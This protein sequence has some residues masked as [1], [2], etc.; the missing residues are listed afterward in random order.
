MTPHRSPLAEALRALPL[1]ALLAPSAA[2]GMK[3]DAYQEIRGRYEG[4]TLRLRVDL[5]QMT[6]ARPPNVVSLDGIGH[7]RE[8]ARVLFGRL[9]MVYIERV[10][11]EGGARLGLTIYRTQQEADRFRASN[12]PQ[13]SF[14]NPNYGR[15]LAAFAQLGSTSVD[16]EL[17][18]PK[19]ESEAQVREIETLLNRVFYLDS[20]PTREEAEDF[21]RQHAGLPVD[22]LREL[23]GLEAARIRDLMREAAAP[24]APPAGPAAPAPGPAA[25]PTPAG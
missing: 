6:G 3:R 25:S 22:R 18:A 13:P 11:N 23:T 15:T 12:V 10:T 21:V 20:Q 9:E 1:L 14:A 16:L 24:A 4:M 2:T 17:R 5:M 19:S 7:G 8:R